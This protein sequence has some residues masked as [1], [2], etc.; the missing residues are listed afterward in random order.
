[1]M[2]L[3]FISETKTKRSED[4]GETSDANRQYRLPPQRKIES[5]RDREMV[6][7]Q[8]NTMADAEKAYLATLHSSC[9][10]SPHAPF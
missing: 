7:K 1:M 6:K 8:V 9:F 5:R 2:M 3:S 4:N 10:H